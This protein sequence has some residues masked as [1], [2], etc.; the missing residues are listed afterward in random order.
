MSD[1]FKLQSL[2][3][4]CQLPDPALYVLGSS[5]KCEAPVLRDGRMGTCGRVWWSREKGLFAKRLVWE[6]GMDGW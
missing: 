3:H 4:R 6:D 5:I 1:E 2:P